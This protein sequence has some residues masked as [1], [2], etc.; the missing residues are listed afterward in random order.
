MSTMVM[1][2]EH[3]EYRRRS[4]WT[5]SVSMVAHALIMLWIA[6]A[7]HVAPAVPELTEI[8]LIEPGEL[9]GTPA[10]SGQP[11]ASAA[12]ERAGVA[13]IHRVSE[14]F[15]RLTARDEVT[16]EPE[17]PDALADRITARLAAIHETTPAPVKGLSPSPLADAWG[18]PTAPAGATGGGGSAL[19]L[20]R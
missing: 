12:P 2:T 11:S 1:R 19:S 8:T 20:H 16:P 10:A 15:R 14:S 4:R 17:S 5:M 7:P 9:G 6:L 3:E 18:T 13:V